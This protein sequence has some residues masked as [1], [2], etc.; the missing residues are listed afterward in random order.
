MKYVAR[1]THTIDNT[2]SEN[3]G[4]PVARTILLVIDIVVALVVGTL[5]PR[6]GH[7]SVQNLYLFVFVFKYKSS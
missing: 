6:Q 7:I 2:D 4:I 3:P 5:S 1:R